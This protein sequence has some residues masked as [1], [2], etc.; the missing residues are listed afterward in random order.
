VNAYFK[1]FKSQ[2]GW[3]GLTLLLLTSPLCLAQ[4]IEDDSDP[5]G[6]RRM[7]AE[8]ETGGNRFVL[9]PHKR[10]YF[11]FRYMDNPNDDAFRNLQND[12]GA[13]LDDAE[14]EFQVS[15]KVAMLRDTFTAGDAVQF[16]FTL[17]SFWQTF[18]N[19]QSSP[20]RE[21]NY[22]PEVWYR[23]P[24][25]W[26][27]FGSD[28]ML[29]GIGAEHQSNGRSREL[30]RSWN[31]IYTTVTW[32]TDSYAFRFKPWYRI[33]ED[34]KDEPDD[35]DGDDNPDIHRY[36]G[37]FEFTGIYHDDDQEFGFML[38]NN[39]GSGASNSRGAIQ[40]DYTFPLWGRVRG[41][42]KLFNGYGESLIDYNANVT[43]VGLGFLL[44]DIL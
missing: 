20:F 3:F 15:I 9:T 28:T 27:T 43:S 4:E 18:N 38:R 11:Q 14:T 32:L 44:S 33:P 29:W 42:A 40:L 21:T 22:Q 7:Q 24:L 5:V 12:D 2:S 16:G 35:T 41:Y 37:Y 23:T 34:R 10:N 6:S 1:N 17:K 8:A 30:S 26:N 31:R 39:V 13:D 36:M 25:P 19:D